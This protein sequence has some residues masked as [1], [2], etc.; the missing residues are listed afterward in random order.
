MISAKRSGILLQ[1]GEFYDYLNPKGNKFTIEDIAL[2]LSH[3]CRY[4]GQVDEFL[5]VA[6]HSVYVS[7]CI[8]PKYALDGLMHDAVEAFMLDIPTPLK[9]LLPDYQALEKIHEAE[10]FHRFGLAYPMVDDVKLADKMVL[11]AEIDQLKPLSGHWDDLADIIRYDGEIRCL[12]PYIAYELFLDRYYELIN[13][14]IE[15]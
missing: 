13:L 6:E 12:P 1:S 7:Y 15:H 14:R 9:S 2:S 4:A 3:I 5:S 8:D 10:L 11:C